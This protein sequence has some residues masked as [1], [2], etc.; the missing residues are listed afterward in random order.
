MYRYR[1]ISPLLFD[2]TMLE[3]TKKLTLLLRR[4]D[5]TIYVYE[6]C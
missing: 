1:Y 4:Y 2:V 3:W 5:V 6:W